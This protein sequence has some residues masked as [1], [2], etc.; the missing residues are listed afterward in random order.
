MA[1]Y[2]GHSPVDA[3]VLPAPAIVLHGFLLPSL[4]SHANELSLLDRMSDGEHRYGG[5][6][7]RVGRRHS[8]TTSSGI[9]PPPFPGSTRGTWRSTG[10]T[11]SPC[12]DGDVFRSWTT[13]CRSGSVRAFTYYFDTKQLPTGS[14]ENV[15]GWAP[16]YSLAAMYYHGDALVRPR[17]R[18]TT[19][20]RRATSNSNTYLSES[21]I[22]CGRRTLPHPVPWWGTV[23]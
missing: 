10:G 14:H 13:A 21:D 23:R 2:F 8:V 19:S 15:H 9:L 18:S 11:A 22:A 5:K 20:I 17:Y 4:P 7:L 6:V 16:V 1:A 12:R 3:C